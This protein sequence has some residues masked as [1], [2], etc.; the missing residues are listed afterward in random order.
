[1]A[2]FKISQVRICQGKFANSKEPFIKKISMKNLVKILDKTATGPKPILK[3][4]EL[5][6]MVKKK[7]TV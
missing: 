3:T 7:Y 4:Y 6:A 1:L 2:N 5:E